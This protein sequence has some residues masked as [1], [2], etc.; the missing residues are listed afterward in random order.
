MLF[1]TSQLSETNDYINATNMI[2]YKPNMATI[3]TT[4]KY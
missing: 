1:Y 3:S 4:I 2:E